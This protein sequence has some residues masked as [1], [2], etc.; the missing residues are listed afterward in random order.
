MC[1]A[2]HTDHTISPTTQALPLL[3]CQFFSKLYINCKRKRIKKGHH[4][5]DAPEATVGFEP[6]DEGFA[7]L[8]LTTWP[9]RLAKK[10]YTH[11]GY[12]F[13]G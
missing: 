8:C 12:C 13:Q 2:H 3:N 6:T 5:Y 7:N 4:N 9:R 1:L 11:V 10:Q